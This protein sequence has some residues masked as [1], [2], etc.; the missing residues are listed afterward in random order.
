[1]EEEEQGEG[2]AAGRRKGLLLL[3]SK[4]LFCQ[5]GRNKP[6]G[7]TCPPTALNKQQV[8]PLHR[9]SDF[10]FATKP[11]EL[12]HLRVVHSLTH[13]SESPGEVF[14]FS[15][16]TIPVCSPGKLDLNQWMARVGRTGRLWAWV[17]QNILWAF[18]YWLLG[19]NPAFTPRGCHI[20]S[21]QTY[22][23]W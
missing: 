11:D 12:N 3:P 15:M 23:G 4:G 19:R 9:C 7:R 1:M 13:F 14:L 6:S 5:L 17:L 18:C 20:L 21:Q 22:L 8:G 16:G 10:F 2:E